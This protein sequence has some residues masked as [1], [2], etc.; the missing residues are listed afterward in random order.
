MI[1]EKK[2]RR[3]SV[4]SFRPG[5]RFRAVTSDLLEHDAATDPVEGVGKV[6]LKDPFVR[7]RK[8]V[9]VEDGVGSMNYGFSATF[10]ADA[11]LERRQV[12]A[13]VCRSLSCDAL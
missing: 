9:V 4:A 7:D 10:D 1:P 12:V 5:R 11:E 13:R 3:T 6:H 2:M 8:C